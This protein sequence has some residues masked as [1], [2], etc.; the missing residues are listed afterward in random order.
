MA[1]VKDLKYLQLFDT[2]GALLT[3]TQRE[4]CEQYYLYDLSLS[5]IAEEKGVSKQSVSDTLKKSRELC[6]FYEEKLG[7]VAR[8][9]ELLAML[10]T[11]TKAHSEIAD[12]V[13]K[14]RDMVAVGEVV[15]LD[16]ED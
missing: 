2:Y 8:Q 15:D 1:C 4:M 7:F 5:E 11:L 9:S 12:E 3:D 10:D 13:K 14:I 16:E 6:E